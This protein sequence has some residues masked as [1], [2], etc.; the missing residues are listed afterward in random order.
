[1][2]TYWLDGKK[3]IHLQSEIDEENRKMALSQLG[4]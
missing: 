1:M 3:N 2:T 4:F